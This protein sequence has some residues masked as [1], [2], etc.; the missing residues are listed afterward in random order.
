MGAKVAPGKCSTFAAE[1]AQ[2]SWLKAH[3]WRVLQK[4][5]PVVNN[6]RDL[7]M[8]LD[9]SVGRRVGTTSTSWM[10]TTTKAFERLNKYKAKYKRKAA[11]IRMKMLPRA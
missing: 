6:W 8:H 3:R 1:A 10:T 7:G 4:T 9:S 5:I 11:V 2:R